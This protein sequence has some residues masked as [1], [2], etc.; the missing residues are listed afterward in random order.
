MSS[1]YIIQSAR[2]IYADS[3]IYK[4]YDQESSL[5]MWVLNY[6]IDLIEDEELRSFLKYIDGLRK[7]NINM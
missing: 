7:E 5:S 3:I 6:E 1:R 2:T 4:L